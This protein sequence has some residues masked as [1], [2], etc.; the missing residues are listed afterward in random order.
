VRGRAALVLAIAAIRLPTLTEPGWYSDDGFFM[1]VGWS[2][3]KGLPLYAGVFDNSPPGIYWLFRGL[4]ALGAAEHNWIVQLAAT[5]AVAS[6]AL[7][8]L[9]IAGRLIPGWPAGLAAT[10]T[11]GLLSVPTLDGNALN[12]ELAGMPF[13][14]GALA[15]ALRPQRA[16]PA[17]A[18]LLLAAAVTFRPSYAVEAVAVL[19]PLMTVSRRARERLMVAVAAGAA[20]LLLVGAAL[21]AT[22]SLGAYVR[23]V[24]PAN[25]GYLLWSNGGSYAPLVLRLGLLAVAGA[26]A[27]V[28]ASSTGGRLASVWLPAALGAASLT[29]REF[30]HYAQEAIPAI[31]FTAA[32]LASR[33]RFRT[34]AG[35]AAAA[36]SL[37]LVQLLLVLPAWQT[38]G[39][40]G[41]AAGWHPDIPYSRLQAYYGNWFRYV[42]GGVSASQYS[43]W[44][45]GYRAEE[46]AAAALRDLTVPGSRVVV[47]GDEP[48]LFVHTRSLPA[49][50]Y[51]ATNSAFWQV[52]SAPGE[53]RIGIQTGSAPIVVIPPNG[54][55]W[56]GDVLAGPYAE[57]SARPWPIFGH[58]GLP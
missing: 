28:R 21:A 47:V 8:V 51:L 9:H 18:G 49:T 25:H 58:R 26:T 12:V 16:A 33:F 42:T 37:V 1:A 20:G 34:L 13:F 7:L 24:T 4:I 22:G 15:V 6:S 57:I 40:Q 19:V 35:S 32:L 56:E 38:G 48:W 39:T 55:G 53:M 23:V 14:L 50:R 17:A 45:P 52:P 30:S 31:A 5:L 44:F 10:V 43:D 3:S 36:A 29:P 41:A 11:A 54:R 27:Y 46:E 2:M